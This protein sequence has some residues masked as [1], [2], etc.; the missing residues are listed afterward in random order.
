MAMGISRGNISIQGRY[1]K[2]CQ[3]ISHEFTLDR[4]KEAFNDL[5]VYGTRE[6]LIQKYGERVFGCFS[7]KDQELLLKN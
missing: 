4:C 5:A 6:F 2:N 7:K 3:K 1:E